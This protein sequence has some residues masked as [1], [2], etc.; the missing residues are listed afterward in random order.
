ML[1][2]GVASCRARLLDGFYSDDGVR[3][4]FF[5]DVFAGGDRVNLC[6]I[7]PRL[8]VERV[9]YGLSEIIEVYP[10]ARSKIEINANTVGFAGVRF[11]CAAGGVS[12]S[13][14]DTPFSVLSLSV[15]VGNNLFAVDLE[16]RARFR[17]RLSWH[18]Q[19]VLC[20]RRAHAA[21]R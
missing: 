11:G 1:E 14:S 13:G 18:H 15:S 3:L 19:H 10:A 21:G 8:A 12:P 4:R 2:W 6:I 20:G 17:V 9:E 7:C 16:S 5:A